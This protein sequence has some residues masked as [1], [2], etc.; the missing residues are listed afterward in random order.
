MIFPIPDYL[1]IKI[2]RKKTCEKQ[3]LKKPGGLFDF[4]L[5]KDA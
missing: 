5:Q 2:F 3:S 4:A 1:F